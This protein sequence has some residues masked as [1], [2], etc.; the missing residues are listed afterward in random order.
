M[1][2]D[3]KEFINKQCKLQGKILNGRILSAVEVLQR[4]P[5]V[6]EETIQALGLK[7]DLIREAVYEEYRS[8]RNAIT[9]YCEGREYAKLPIFK[10]PTK[11]SNES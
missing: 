10:N 9:F 4:Q 7:K 2:R 6:S 1:D 11:D 5:G 8:L 3:L